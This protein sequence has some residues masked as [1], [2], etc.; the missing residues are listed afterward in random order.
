[1][2]DERH[3]V[4]MAWASPTPHTATLARLPSG[5]V[6]ARGA[7]TNVNMQD[8][9][10]SE[11]SRAEKMMLQVASELCRAQVVPVLL[12]EENRRAVGLR[13]MYLSADEAREIEALLDNPVAQPKYAPLRLPMADA[14]IFRRNAV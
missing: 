5:H 4:E 11:N 10:T 8:W 14:S 2:G 1:M 7:A 3:S 12:A 13:E 9:T 6:A